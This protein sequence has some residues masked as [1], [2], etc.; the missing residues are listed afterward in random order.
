MEKAKKVIVT[1][2]SRGIGAA[3]V[4]KFA[5]NGYTVVLCYNK[6]EESARTIAASYPSV[7][8]HKADIS[9]R[10]EAMSLINSHPDADVLINNAGVA[11]FGLF[12]DITPSQEQALYGVNLFGTLGCTRAAV[13]NMLHNGHG[14]IINISSMWGRDGA[15]C[16]VDYSV[17]K[18]AII[19][20][21]T[22]LS[23]EVGPAG[24]RVNCICPG[25]ID[26]DMNANLDF[27][28]VQ[29][30]IDEIPLERLGTA[31][32]TANAAYFLASDDASYITGAVL[33]VDGGIR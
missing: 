9:V 32:E 7:I 14:V 3:T 18:A 5:E 22:A 12:D 6:S 19:G 33:D 26:T 30:I 4:K 8:L 28:E 20:L 1:G 21:T 27:G 15:S 11:L 29:A 25:V 2:G 24:I 31:E 10:E 16:E 17:S 13:K 23:K